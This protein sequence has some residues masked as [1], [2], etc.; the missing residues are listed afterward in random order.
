MKLCKNEN[1]SD[2][3]CQERITENEEFPYKL[4]K[5][6][7]RMVDEPPIL[8]DRPILRSEDAVNLAQELFQAYDR[9]VFGV[10]NLQASGT[11][12]NFN[13]VSVGSLMA[14]LTSPREVMKSVVL[15]NSAGVI[16]I[17]N[18]PGGNMCPS[19]DDIQ[20][21]ERI[22]TVMDLMGVQLLDHII[23]G[24]G[25]EY[26]SFAEH[27]EKSL[28]GKSLDEPSILPVK[29]VAC[30]TATA[31]STYGNLSKMRALNIY[32]SF[33][34]ECRTILIGPDSDAEEVLVRE[35]TKYL[36]EEVRC[37]SKLNER[38]CVLDR[39]QGFGRIE[40]DN[41]DNTEFQINQN[42]EEPEPADISV[43]EIAYELY[44]L[45]W[46]RTRGWDYS[47]VRKAELRDE[48]YNGQMYVCYDEFL[49]TEYTHERF[50]D[51]LL[52][53]VDLLEQLNREKGK[54]APNTKEKSEELN[55]S[56]KNGDVYINGE[57]VSQ[58]CWDADA[59]GSAVAA[60][61]QDHQ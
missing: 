10:I 15:S 14:T 53:D 38:E 55:V 44:K 26:Y 41:G 23:L 50:I 5:V 27:N 52:S 57:F 33:D 20:L 59:V 46:C 3:A 45:N 8:S 28:K 32:P 30:Q 21:T 29:A 22:A 2:T 49:N 40:W 58:L 13:T 19:S 12:I 6:A 35:Y 34:C 43:P 11:P 24:R 47:A 42:L 9:E 36:M 31:D 25:K 37:E 17:H 18:H 7:I 54:S 39:S 48:E 60:W 16:L 4:N 1:V 56:L 61:L 51:S